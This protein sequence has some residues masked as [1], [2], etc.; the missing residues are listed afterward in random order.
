MMMIQLRRL[1]LRMRLSHL[2]LLLHSTSQPLTL[3]TGRQRSPTHF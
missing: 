3:L 1:F 2:L